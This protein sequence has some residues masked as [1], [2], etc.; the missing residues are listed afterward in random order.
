M[1]HEVHV[2]KSVWHI[3]EMFEEFIANQFIRQTNFRK[4]TK[5]TGN[6]QLFY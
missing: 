2:L 5:Q 6:K 1:N 3:T 4:K